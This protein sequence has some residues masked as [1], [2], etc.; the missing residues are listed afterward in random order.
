MR[1]VSPSGPVTRVQQWHHIVGVTV[2]LRPVSR[3]VMVIGAQA[4]HG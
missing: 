1:A 4:V 3:L 2:T